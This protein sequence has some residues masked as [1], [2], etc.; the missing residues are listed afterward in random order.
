MNIN[1]YFED[2]RYFRN[3]IIVISAKDEAS[4]KIKKFT[5]KENL[6]L[7]MKIGYRGAYVA[8]VDF[9]RGFCFEKSTDDKYECAYRVGKKYIDIVSSGYNSG[10]LS[11]IK[12]GDSEY[13]KNRRGLNVAVF[14]YKSLLLVDSFFVDTNSDNDLKLM[15]H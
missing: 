14:H 15:R 13:S 9:K 3:K 10:P 6:N 4:M 12:V 8:V 2:M 5:N 11:S 7:E 1:E